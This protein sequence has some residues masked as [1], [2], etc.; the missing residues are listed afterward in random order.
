MLLTGLFPD[1]VVGFD[2]PSPKSS[3]VISGGVEQSERT[4]GEFRLVIGINAPDVLDGKGRPTGPP[5]IRQPIQAGVGIQIDQI[6]Q[7]NQREENFG[8]V[9]DLTLHWQDPAFA[10]NPDTCQCPLKVLDRTQFEKFVAENHLQWPRFV[11]FNQQGNRWTQ[12]DVF[13]IYPDGSVTYYERLSVTLQAP[14]FNFQRFPLDTQTFYIRLQGL[15]PEEDYQFTDLAKMTGIGQQLGEEEWYIIQHD[16]SISSV[17]IPDDGS[18]SQYSFRFLCRRH[19]SFYIFRIFLPLGLIIAVS[20]VTFF[21]QNYAK[22]VDISGANLLVFIAFNFTI[23]SDLPRLGYLTLLDTVLIIAF[24]I[25]TLGVICSVALRRLETEGK[26]RLAN[27][28]DAYIL[29][30]YPSLYVLG[31]LSVVLVFFL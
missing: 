1:G 26:T 2:E 28:I 29:W 9:G 19:L 20:W 18:V 15:Y 10:F 14:D 7:V 27:K 6:A 5:I 8:V 25:T 23:G 17:L 31:F 24:V 16:I 11:F 22:R 12:G 21:L 30:G 4:T 13:R 3:L